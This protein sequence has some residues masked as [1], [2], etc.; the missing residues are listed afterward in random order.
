[1]VY[2]TERHSDAC[3]TNKSRI[4]YRVDE[5]AQICVFASCCQFPRIF[6][7]CLPL[8]ADGPLSRRT[9]IGRMT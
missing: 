4:S 2:T 3:N 5:N 9:P 6:A 7:L 1:M 8:G